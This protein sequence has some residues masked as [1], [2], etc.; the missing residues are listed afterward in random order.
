MQSVGQGFGGLAASEE[1]FV[2][3]TDTSVYFISA[4]VVTDL[5]R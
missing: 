1:V 5:V 2:A 4:H 3:E